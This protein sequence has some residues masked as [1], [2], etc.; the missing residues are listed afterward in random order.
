MTTNIQVDTVKVPNV[1]GVPQNTMPAPTAPVSPADQSA[2]AIINQA[3]GQYGLASLADWAW[4]QYTGGA[5]IEQ[6]MLDMRQRPEYKQRFPAMD[7]LAQGGHALSEAQYIQAEQSYAQIMH[8]AGVPAGF[9]DQPADFSKLLTGFVSPTELQSRVQDAQTAIYGNPEIQQQLNGLYGAGASPGQ[10]LAYFI[11]PDRAEPLIA[12][13]LASAQVAAAGV[14]SGYGQVN[15]NEAE[16]IAEQ[17][18][19]QQEITS[20][21][22]T[23]GQ[24]QWLTKG[25]VGG[26]EAAGETGLS[27]HDLLGAAFLGDAKAQHRLLTIQ[28][29]RKADQEA[30]GQF[31]EAKPGTGLTGIGVDPASL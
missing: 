19:S 15:R 22:Q 1:G 4:K 21:F 25:Q 5:A 11:D 29:Q 16:L 30:G 3:L 12:K 6:I 24:E 13:Q 2:R 18:M 23:I 8:A 14:N 20:R 10:I 27:A 7:A 28:Q 26:N 31:A 17:N 9:Y